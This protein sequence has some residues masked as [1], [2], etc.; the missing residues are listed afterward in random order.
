MRLADFLRTSL[1][2]GERVMIPFAEELALTRMY[3]DVE[4]VRFGK[5]LRLVQDVEAGC[6]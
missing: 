3:L 6:D 1:R 4:Q 5:Q 2:L